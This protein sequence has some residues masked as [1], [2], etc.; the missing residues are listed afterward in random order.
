VH[1]LL[2][3]ELTPSCIADLVNDDFVP[4]KVFLGV[5]LLLSFLAKALDGDLLLPAIAA[6]CML[7]L[8]L[9]H[10][11]IDL[12]QHVDQPKLA[13]G[14]CSH[15]G[16]FIQRHGLIARIFGPCAAFGVCFVSWAS[17]NAVATNES[18]ETNLNKQV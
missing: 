10:G 2:P 4:D 1:F 7:V 13:F 6:P 11:F 14:H 3:G 12:V 18:E 8:G 9:G 15:L 17:C 5:T 16:K